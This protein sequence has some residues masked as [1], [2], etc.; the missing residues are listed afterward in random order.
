VPGDV[1]DDVYIDFSDVKHLQPIQ[2]ESECNR[3]GLVAQYCRREHDLP[4]HCDEY[5]AQHYHESDDDYYNPEHDQRHSSTTGQPGVTSNTSDQ[6]NSGQT[7]TPST[8][9]DQN[10]QSSQTSSSQ[11]QNAGATNADNGQQ[12]GNQLP[13]TASPLP[14]L[15]LLGL[16]GI[17]AG[18]ISRRRK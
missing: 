16:G 13:Q 18:I 10:T 4:A 11:S 1:D 15:G 3:A 2:Y 6:T 5:R 14:L 12:S 9:T 17:G 8:T 7:T